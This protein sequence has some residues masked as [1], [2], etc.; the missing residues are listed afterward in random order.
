VRYR[1]RRDFLG[2]CADLAKDRADVHKWA[3]VEATQV[4]PVDARLSLTM[5]RVVT[6]LALGLV[7]LLVTLFWP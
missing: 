4:F 2:L 7:A 6:G 3:A 5:I 1:S